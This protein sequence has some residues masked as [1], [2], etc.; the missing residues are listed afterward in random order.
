LHYP[1]SSQLESTHQDK[2][3]KRFSAPVNSFSAPVNI[4]DAW[5]PMIQ[6]RELQ[7]LMNWLVHFFES[8]LALRGV[9]S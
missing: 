1:L 3:A 8:L 9:Q 6:E 5:F 7:S 4:R 2:T